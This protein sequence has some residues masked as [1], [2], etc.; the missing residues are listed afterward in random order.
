MRP[1]VAEPPQFVVAVSDISDRASQ[2]LDVF[3]FLATT[4]V[5]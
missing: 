1:M 5:I 3:R 2:R 4:R